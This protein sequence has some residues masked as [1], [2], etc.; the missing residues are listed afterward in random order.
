[1]P[2]RGAWSDGWWH[3][4]RHCPSP[5]FGLRPAGSDVSLAVVHAISLPPGQ[6]GGD[7]VERFF[8]NTLDGLAHP[9]FAGIQ[10]LRVSAHFFIRRSGRMVQF[11]S[12]NS[13]AWHAG[14]GSLQPTPRR[15]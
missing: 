4:A 13:R 11:V 6:W 14:V 2:R 15:K 5:N 1:M 7:S 12:C 3:G 9:Y 8:T 10:G